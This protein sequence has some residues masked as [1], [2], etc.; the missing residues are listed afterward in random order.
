MPERRETRDGIGFFGWAGLLALLLIIFGGAFLYW[1][2]H[3]NPSLSNDSGAAPFAATEDTS[4]EPVEARAPPPEEPA[5]ETKPQT[6]SPKPRNTGFYYGLKD[7]SEL[8]KLVEDNLRKDPTGKT[9]INPE[10]CAKDGSCAS[11]HDYLVMFQENDPEAELTSVAQLPAFLRS[12]V[13]R[14]PGPGEYQMACIRMPAHTPDLHC[15]KRKFLPGEKVYVDPKSNRAIFAWHCTN[16]IDKPVEPRQC[17]EIM[18]TIKGERSM[19]FAHL[20]PAKVQDSCLALRKV[21]VGV[22]PLREYVGECDFDAVAEFFGERVREEYC[23]PVT[24]G[25]YILTVAAK[26]YGEPKTRHWWVFCWSD[27][28]DVSSNTMRVRDFDYIG[29]DVRRATIYNSRDEMEDKTYPKSVSHL[30]IPWS[31]EPGTDR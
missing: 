9:M 29:N 30:W 1:D 4:T 26:P 22:I 8:A 6:D 7:P 23:V 14:D 19:K 12:L 10:K 11:P 31:E 20:G 25:T 2:T 16:P 5:A 13:A 28:D 27:E 3:R 21:G 24:P 18:V 15:M 17:M